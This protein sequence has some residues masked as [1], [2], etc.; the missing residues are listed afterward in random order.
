MSPVQHREEEETKIE[1]ESQTQADEV[2]KPV[3]VCDTSFLVRV[4]EKPKNAA[5]N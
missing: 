1:T 4:L 5:N 2:S 3:S